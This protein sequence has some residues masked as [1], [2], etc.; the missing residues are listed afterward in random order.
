ML[1][2]KQ[3]QGQAA[4]QRAIQH[5]ISHGLSLVQKNFLCKCGEIDLIM[6]DHHTLV[7][8]EV[9]YREYADFGSAAE[10]VTPAKQRK[11]CNT[12]SYYLQKNKLTNKVD[13][14][15]DVVAIDGDKL[16]W[17]KSAFY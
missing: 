6:Q 8:V 14:R 9:R 11:I 5:L 1:T 17:I 13:C 12:A 2:D 10:S 3:Q 7:F 15:F 16:S 4:E